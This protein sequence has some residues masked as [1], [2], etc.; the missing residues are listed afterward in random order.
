LP[1]F[2]FAP[3]AYEL[4]EIRAR[5]P[6]PAAGAALRGE[7]RRWPEA[8]AALWRASDCGDSG[9]WKPVGAIIDC[10]LSSRTSGVFAGRKLL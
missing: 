10:R 7:P 1:E 4:L 5:A 8:A 6:N 2:W 3:L 9:I